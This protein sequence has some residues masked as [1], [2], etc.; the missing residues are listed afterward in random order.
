M[1]TALR[2]PDGK[3]NV[4]VVEPIFLQNI[5]IQCSPKVM[6]QPNSFFTS[7]IVLACLLSKLDNCQDYSLK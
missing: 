1:I 4:Q 7:P 3:N 6:D 2:R 5:A